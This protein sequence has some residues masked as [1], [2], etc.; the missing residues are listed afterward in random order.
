[1]FIMLID[2]I[3]EIWSYYLTC[4]MSTH[5]F[6]KFQWAYHIIGIAHIRMHKQIQYKH[7]TLGQVCLYLFILVVNSFFNLNLWS[8]LEYFQLKM[9]I[10]DCNKINF[11]IFVM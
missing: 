11:L 7:S 2:M 5:I 3:D 9:L 10:R 4:E 6:F 1:M 8:I